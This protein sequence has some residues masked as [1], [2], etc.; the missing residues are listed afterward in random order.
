[1]RLRITAPVYLE[2]KHRKP[3]D[4]CEVSDKGGH[5]CICLGRGELAPVEKIEARE[6]VIETRDPLPA[7]APPTPRKK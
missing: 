5:L 3:G 1:M 6:P 2:G 4:I 7:T